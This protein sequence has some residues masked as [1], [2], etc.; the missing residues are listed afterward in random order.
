MKQSSAWTRP[1][2]W[3][4][5]RVLVTG[6]GGFIGRMLARRLAEAGAE[7]HGT[8][9]S[10]PPTADG[11]TPHPA[12]LPDDAE[13]VLDHVRP[14]VV[15]HLASPVSPGTAP[16]SY[17]TLRPGI[18]DAT[19]AMANGSAKLGARLVYTCTCEALAGGPVPFAPDHVVPTSPYSALKAAGA[20]WIRMLAHS[21]GL[22][23]VVVRPFRTW[24]PGERRGLVYEA[25]RAALDR[26][27]LSLTDG[28]QVREWNHVDAIVTGLIALAAHP[29]AGGG[30]WSLGG[31]PHHSVAAF[32]HRIF[33]AAGAP[34]SLVEVGTQARRAGEVD[35]F[36]GDHSQTDALIGPLP[37]PDLALAL[38]DLVDWTSEATP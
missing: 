5:R 7:V 2:H 34:R 28:S 24:G 37:H 13:R 11:I 33:D 21:H 4:G 18:L 8:W 22:D 31:G 20:A 15:F 25:V 35:A 17:H 9:R 1:Q 29:Q 16:A 10:R 36:W 6:A 12:L 38:Q 23:G 3:L 30:V 14:E 27:P 26:R 32:A 19:V